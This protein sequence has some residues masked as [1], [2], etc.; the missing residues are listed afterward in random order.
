MK[1]M[2]NKGLWSDFKSIAIVIIVLALLFFTANN[3]FGK[4][5]NEFNKAFC[6]GDMD[7]DGIHYRSPTFEDQCPCGDQEDD[8]TAIGYK[9]RSYPSGTSGMTFYDV[10][11]ASTREDGVRIIQ[12]NVVEHIKGFLNNPSKPIYLVDYNDAKLA[13]DG[14]GAYSNNQGVFCRSASNDDGTCTSEDFLRDFFAEDSQ[15]RPLEECTIPAHSKECRDAYVA[16]CDKQ[17]EDSKNT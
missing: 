11:P 8:P 4:S 1:Y 3:V 15:G 9:L 6:D 16:Y 5:N 17:K 12:L 2:N 14:T 7:G 13:S 10:Q